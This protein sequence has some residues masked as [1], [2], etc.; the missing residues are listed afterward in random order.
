MANGAEWIWNI[1][2]QQ[3]AGAIQI[4]L[5]PFETGALRQSMSTVMGSAVHTP[6]GTA[7]AYIYYRRV[8]QQ[9]MQYDV[10]VDT[11]A[12]FVVPLYAA[13]A[14]GL[15]VGESVTDARRAL[16]RAMR[17]GSKPRCRSS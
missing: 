16:Y 8:A 2:D 6:T 3:F 13:L 12:R 14:A 4:V 11:A 17:A 5:L 10:R 15:P 7:V 9:A 1:A